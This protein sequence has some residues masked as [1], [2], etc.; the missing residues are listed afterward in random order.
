[1][2]AVLYREHLWR[3]NRRETLWILENF[4]CLGHYRCNW[5]SYFARLCWSRDCRQWVIGFCHWNRSPGIGSGTECRQGIANFFAGDFRCGTAHRFFVAR[6][7][8]CPRCRPWGT[9]PATGINRVINLSLASDGKTY[10]LYSIGR[11]KPSGKTYL[12]CA[13]SNNVPVAIA[14]FV[15]VKS[16]DIP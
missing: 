16:K 3:R 4:F 14:G 7:K 13:A 15:L 10:Q 1:M 6:R 12:Y 9:S 11:C 2:Y 8:T 5:N